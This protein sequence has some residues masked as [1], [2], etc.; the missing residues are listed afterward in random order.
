M[1][2][3][4]VY[5]IRPVAELLHYPERVIKILYN[6]KRTHGTIG[7]L[8]DIAI[9][10]GINIEPVPKKVLDKLVPDGPHQGIVARANEYEYAA[11]RHLFNVRPPTNRSVILACD[12]ITDPQNFGAMLR[13]LDALGG[14]GAITMKK[15]SVGVTPA[16]CKASAGAVEHLPI[17]QVVNLSRA[18]NAAKEEGFAVY[19]LDMTGE[20]SVF[21]PPEDKKIVL[22]VG[23]EGKGLRRSIRETCDGFIHIP[24][25]GHVD[26]LNASVS[27][28]V[29]L[30]WL[31]H[32]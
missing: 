19:G 2:T 4:L 23:S 3:R 14:I 21:S 22:V 30:S 24:L 26:S 27:V 17:A 5:G 31:L 25:V 28:A 15:R 16:V 8:I 9:E 20:Y 7:E 13:S 6:E 18:L 12:E 29:A 11:L 1:A 10:S 32:G